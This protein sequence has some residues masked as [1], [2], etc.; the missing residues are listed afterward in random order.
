MARG[1][2]LLVSLMTVCC[3]VVEWKDLF[4][5]VYPSLVLNTICVERISLLSLE[6]LL[7]KMERIIVTL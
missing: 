4:F 3:L 1:C 2:R 6:F 7:L 5:S